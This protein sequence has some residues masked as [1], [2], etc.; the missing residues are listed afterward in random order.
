MRRDDVSNDAP[1]SKDVIED[2]LGDA[3]LPRW[4][5]TSV[6]PGVRMSKLL[7]CKVE[8]NPT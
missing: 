7:L 3:K 1:V 8:N 5:H 2:I 4:Q 6:S